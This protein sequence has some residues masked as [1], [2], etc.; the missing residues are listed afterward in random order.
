MN[1]NKV[2]LIDLYENKVTTSNKKRRLDYLYESYA[3]NKSNVS[4]N[5]FH[6]LINKYYYKYAAEVYTFPWNLT[7]Y[8]EDI[9]KNLEPGCDIIDIGAGTGFSYKL[10][11]DIGYNYNKYWFIE[12][13][14]DMSNKLE[15]KDDRLQIENSYIEDCW[16]KIRHSKTKKIFIMNATLHHIIDLE[17]FGKSLRDNMNEDDIFFLPYEPNNQSYLTPL[18]LFY[19]CM[20]FIKEPIKKIKITIRQTSA[21]KFI[22]KYLSKSYTASNDN[23]SKSLQDLIDSDV[24][25]DGFTKEMIYAITDYGVYRN[26]KAID[27]PPEYNEGFYLRSNISKILGLEIVYLKTYSYLHKDGYKFYRK[28]NIIDGFLRNICA[29]SGAFLCIAFKK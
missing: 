18:N 26:W 27:I 25:K 22:Y 16:E 14:K 15:V 6:D 21:F 28:R 24:V 29:K 5:K 13:S 1:K 23:L 10:I 20:G 9:F 11:K 2:K 19:S 8:Y 12:P 7:R 3:S 4:V 17:S